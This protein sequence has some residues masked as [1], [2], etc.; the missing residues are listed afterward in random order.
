MTGLDWPLSGERTPSLLEDRELIS[1]FETFEHRCPRYVKLEDVMTDE[2][3]G[4]VSQLDEKS[5]NHLPRLF[6]ATFTPSVLICTALVKLCHNSLFLDRP[7]PISRHNRSS[8]LPQARRQS[9]PPL[10]R[11]IWPPSGCDTLHPVLGYSAARHFD[12]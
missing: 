10:H 12:N 3:I 1:T 7:R 11:G 4:N 8:Y 9:Y 2:R 6:L 5:S